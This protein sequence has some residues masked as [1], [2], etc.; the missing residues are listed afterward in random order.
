MGVYTKVNTLMVKLMFDSLKGNMLRNN[1][2]FLIA[3]TALLVLNTHISSNPG[4]LFPIR[5]YSGI[6]YNNTWKNN[7]KFAPWKV[8][9]NNIPLTID[10][11]DP[12]EVRYHL[13]YNEYKL[14]I[15]VNINDFG[16]IISSNDKGHFYINFNN[17][18]KM[19]LILVKE[20]N[21]LI[22]KLC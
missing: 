22:Y 12:L 4:P 19:T 16:K 10:L 20:N 18:N 5:F 14:P 17:S 9:T 3:A 8:D 11:I 21:K 6:P 1:F 2:N 13:F 7:S 15:S